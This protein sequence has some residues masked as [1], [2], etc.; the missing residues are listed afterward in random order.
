MKVLVIGSGGREHALV[1]K[2]NQS[3]CDI[4]CAP[5]NGGISTMATCVPIKA[6]NTSLIVEFAKKE[7]FDLTIVGPEVPLGL[8]IVDE[9]NKYGLKIFGPN[10]YAAQLETS[11]AFARDFCRKYNL[12]APYYENFTDSTKAKSYVSSKTYPIVIKA[13]GLAAGKGA[14]IVKNKEEAFTTIE[15]ILEKK[16]FGSAGNT[17]VIE[18]FI[19][20]QE[21]SMLALCDA[22]TIV[23]LI[24]ARDHKPLLD[25]NKGPN[26]G[27]MGSFAPIPEL[28]DDW[29]SNIKNNLFDPMIKALKKENIE[30]KGVIYAG[31][32]ISGN[33]FY[34]IEFNCRWGDPEAEV[35]I[36]LLKTDMVKLC[37]DTI[38]GKLENL[39]WKDEY[40][41][42]V[43]AASGGYPE[44]YEA[45]KLIVSNLTEKEDT[46]IFH[47]GTKKE[48]NN[49]YSAGGRVL[50]ITGIAKS[51]AAARE[52]S[53]QALEKIKFDMMYYRTDIG[54]K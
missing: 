42:T 48:G 34:V 7:K 52:K 18:D 39:E 15:R 23:P 16:Q 38:N 29:V 33:N 14:I 21:V 5:G 24:P 35:L 45:G 10:K 27:G 2:L 31:L 30:Y 4:Y 3:N 53:Y 17:I 9:F 54:S 40:A 49:F 32:I 20:G 36:P 11:K 50:S 41:L 12:P 28:N 26:T 13:S 25:G 6:D 47:C 46:I 1:W 44:K 8:G 37:Y 51:L 19:I 43:V 22:N